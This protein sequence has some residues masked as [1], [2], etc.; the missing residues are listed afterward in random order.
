MSLKLR[1]LIADDSAF[2]RRILSDWTK[3]EPD[4]ELVGSASN[5]Q[6]AVEKVLA[7]QPDVV[8]LDLEM[9]VKDGL[10]ALN[11][12][13]KASPVPVLMSCT[14]CDSGI[15]KV[16]EALQCG[17]YDFISKPH[18]ATPEQQFECQMEFLTKIRAARGLV[19]LKPMSR[20]RAGA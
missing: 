4:L 15:Q 20:Q 5:G 11:E 17:A 1:V 10:S 14:E 18:G 19:R 13:V 8:L 2:F 3:N 9:P 12:I 6:E 7:L 16:Q